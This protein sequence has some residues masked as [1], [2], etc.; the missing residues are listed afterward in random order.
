[1]SP[2]SRNLLLMPG[3]DSGTDASKDVL[4]DLPSRRKT[5]AERY[6][7]V[8]KGHMPHMPW[9]HRIPCHQVNE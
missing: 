7:A 5:E 1:V 3:N 6:M 9:P 8:K 2:K 4:Q